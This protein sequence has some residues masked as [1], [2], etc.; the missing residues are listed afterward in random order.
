[1]GQIYA[2]TLA[3]T[4]AA[5]LV[6]VA[7]KDIAM[8]AAFLKDF[9]VPYVF[10][11]ANAAFALDAVEAVII[12]TPTNTHV[13]LVVQAAAAGKA[14][15]CEKPLALSLADT[16]RIL[17][18]VEEAGVLLQVGFMRRFD[19]AYIQVKEAI[20]AGKI[21]CPVTFKSVGRDPFCPPAAFADPAVSGGLIIDMGIHDMDLARWLMGVEVE[22]VSAEGTVMVCDDLEAAGDFDNAVVNL[23]FTN[24]ALGNVEISRNAF[25]GYDIRTEVL[26]S[27]A[28]VRVGAMEPVSRWLL[29]P[30]GREEV[31]GAYLTK[32]FG[33]AY[34]SQIRDFV[35]CVHE[36]RAPLCTGE[37]ALAAFEISLAAT[38]SAEIG[39]PVRLDTV[40]SGWTPGTIQ[41]S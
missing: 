8:Q 29:S 37:D 33:A 20:D 25:Y 27:K 6:A 41:P 34:D 21:G 26:G 32:R 5:H 31:S 35:A 2:N 12:A 23:R 36:D 40:R 3:A 22:R 15:F 28:A 24:G 30:N 39:E 4:E 16:R 7:T 38:Y 14:I 9:D 11:E 13:E 17:Q 19:P 1:M 10:E 18:A